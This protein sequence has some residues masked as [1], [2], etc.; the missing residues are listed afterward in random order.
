MRSAGLVLVGRLCLGV[1]CRVTCDVGEAH[2][3]ASQQ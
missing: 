1:G 3:L 2:V